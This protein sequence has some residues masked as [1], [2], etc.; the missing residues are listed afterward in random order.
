MLL[1]QRRDVQLP[2][3]RVD[4]AFRMHPIVGR[5]EGAR[6]PFSSNFSNILESFYSLQNYLYLYLHLV[7]YI[8]GV[9]ARQ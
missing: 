3:M 1:Q 6:T 8:R 4:P 7:L 9:Y 5:K 2:L